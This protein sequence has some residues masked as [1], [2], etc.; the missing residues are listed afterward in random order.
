M[1]ERGGEVVWDMFS[2]Y[3]AANVEIVR[4]LHQ[5]SL[6]LIL[7]SSS[8]PHY[9]PLSLARSAKA[10]TSIAEDPPPPH[11]GMIQLESQGSGQFPRNGHAKTLPSF[12]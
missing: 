7:A 12:T 3:A 1:E 8:L 10:G 2:R 9:G 11:M 5:F 4:S 6:S